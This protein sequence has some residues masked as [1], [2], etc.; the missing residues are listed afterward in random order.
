[1][2]IL[3]ENPYIEKVIPWNDDLYNNR[4][5]RYEI[6]YDIHNEIILPGSWGRNCNSLLSNFYWKLLDV[7]KGSFFIKEEPFELKKDNILIVHTTGGDPH[8]RTYKYMVDV[9]DYF[10]NRYTTVQVGG[11]KD[12]PAN[13][14]IDL[15][16]KLSYNQT[17]YVVKQA[18]C[19]VTVDSFVSHLVGAYGIPQVCLFGSGNHYV[20]RPEQV[21]GKL[22]CLIPDYLL[23]CPG[24]GPCSGCVK[25]CPA[26]CTGRIDPKEVIKSVLNLFEGN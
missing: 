12:F 15:H 18:K 17:A 20:V 3:K 10:R 2:D 26:P 16:G 1:M 24:L 19:A 9:C 6:V 4:R 13:A 7:E 14:D 22:I 5:D 11:V 25:D 23:D 8:F 21:S